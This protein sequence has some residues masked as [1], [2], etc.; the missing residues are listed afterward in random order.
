VFGLGTALLTFSVPVHSFVDLSAIPP[1]FRRNLHDRAVDINVD[2]QKALVR[3]LGLF[4][5]QIKGD[6]LRL[7]GLARGVCSKV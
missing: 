4:P 3:F 7:R 6:P 5:P 2:H 1:V